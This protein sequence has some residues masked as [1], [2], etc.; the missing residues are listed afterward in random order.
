MRGRVVTLILVF[1]LCFVVCSVSRIELAVAQESP[2]YIRADGKVEPSNI[3][4]QRNGN[5]YTFQN[6]IIN[7]FLYIQ[8]SNVVVDGAN[9]TLQGNGTYFR[10]L[11]VYGDNVTIKNV[12]VS[13]FGSGIQLYA[14]NVTIVR[15]NLTENTCG[16]TISE[17]SSRNRILENNI[18]CNGDK[19][20]YI[21]GGGFNFVYEN[22]ISD[23]GSGITIESSQNNTF[24]GNSLGNVRSNVNIINAAYNLFFDN[25]L[26]SYS[27]ATFRFVYAWNN[28]FHH[29]N[30]FGKTEVLDN[31]GLLSPFFPNSSSISNSSI[32]IWDDGTEGNYWEAYNGSDANLDG[33][34]DTPF[35]IY[36]NNADNYPLIEP[37]L[38]PEFPSWTILP[39]LLTAVLVLAIYKKQLAK[40][41][42]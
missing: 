2:I 5:V 39:L 42:N 7:Y 22:E 20:V 36:N 34:G 29:N 37:V 1:A 10:G 11:L 12:H 24:Y 32:N 28:T 25:N 18:M 35:L 38:I 21:Q 9:Y 14:N 27:G 30:F 40:T 15:N 8:C 16:I 19:G 3:P 26:T 41:P 23:N 31:G 13:Q 33:K 17:S 6:D 4:I